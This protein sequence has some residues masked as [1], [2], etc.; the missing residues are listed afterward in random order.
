MFFLS[1][2]S[3]RSQR[4]I[5]LI[6]PTRLS[7]IFRLRFNP[8]ITVQEAIIARSQAQLR[9]ETVEKQAAIARAKAE[10]K[11]LLFLTTNA[12]LLKLL[13]QISKLLKLNYK[14]LFPPC[15]LK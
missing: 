5:T 6:K 8:E 15:F 11:K 3:A 2:F 7:S 10:L 13:I 4:I 14:Q 12:K 1:C 9:T